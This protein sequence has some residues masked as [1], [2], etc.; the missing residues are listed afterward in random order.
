MLAFALSACGSYRMGEGQ[1]ASSF[2]E[3]DDRAALEAQQRN[4]DA[5]PEAP[6]LD[7]YFKDEMDFTL[8]DL[9][10][11][12]T[13]C[14][15]ILKY[16]N[17]SEKLR[18]WPQALKTFLIEELERFPALGFMH[19]S[20]Y[21]LYLV[22]SDVMTNPETG[23]AA[24]I[25]CDRGKDLR[26]LVFLN[27]ESFVDDRRKGAGKWQDLRVV[28]NKFLLQEAGDNAAVTLI[29]E[30]I[31]TID[32]K[33]F[34][35]GD[36]SLQRLRSKVFD[37]SW[38]SYTEPKAQRIGIFALADGG[39]AAATLGAGLRAF[40]H[41]CQRSRAQDAPATGTGVALADTA[42][43]ESLA[44]DLRYL[45]DK[46]NFVVP[47][48][49]ASAAEDFAESLTVYHFGLNR[50]SWQV[51]TVFDRDIRVTNYR[52]AKSLY[53][54]DTSSILRSND[55]QRDKICALAELLFGECEL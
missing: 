42:S 13:N 12:A 7:S 47:Y 40:G 54:H 5:F 51:R 38:K 55:G 34:V 46:T 41:G 20:L 31:H 39:Q 17:I 15:D 6:E 43:A 3:A 24:G 29:H 18:P 35:H 32:N 36:A 45:A 14:R 4:A 44:E 22:D 52:D 28:T 33:L 2:S 1:D 8:D 10:S 48:T 16:D 9:R 50:K 19:Q 37:M 53:R 49:M 25:A 26:G 23:T 30:V 21:G 11:G 27:Y